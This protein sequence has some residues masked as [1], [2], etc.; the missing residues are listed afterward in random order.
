MRS[1][2]EKERP[3]APASANRASGSFTKEQQLEN[4]SAQASP[5]AIEAANDLVFEHVVEVLDRTESYVRSASEAAWRGDSKILRTHLLQAK[6]CVVAA[7]L[8]FSDLS[9][10][11]QGAH[12]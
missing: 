6:A 2:A 7:L 1:E 10:E 4:S 9:P 12:S 11:G 8:T 5:Q 3:A